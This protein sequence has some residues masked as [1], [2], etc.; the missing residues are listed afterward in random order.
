[1]SRTKKEKKADHLSVGRLLAFKSSDVSQAGIQA[2]I[3][4]YLTIYCTDTFG[5]APGTLGVLL[6]ASKI[7]DAITDLFAGWLVDNTHTKLGK[8]RPYD[9][10]IVGV[11]LCS[12]LLFAGDPNW[13]DAVKC[14]WVFLMY[15][16]VFS[17]FTTLRGAAVTPYTIRAFH[18]NQT[19]IT[20]V[21]SYGGIITML[22]AIIINIVFPQVM[23]RYAVDASGWTKTIAIFAIPLTILG[24]VRFFTCKE[25]PSVDAGEQYKK[26]SPKEILEMFKRNKYVWL[27]AIIMLCY[28]ITT[29]LGVATYYFKYVIGNLGLMSISSMTSIITLPVMFLFPVIMRKMGSMSNMVFRFSLIGIAGYLIELFAG[30]NFPMLLVGTLI[31]GIATLPLA[32]YGVL[33]IMRCCTYN[34]MLGMPRMDASAGILSNFMSKVG[35]AA[36]SAITGIL[37]GAAGYISGTDVAAQPDSAILM[38]RFLMAGVPIICLIIVSICVKKFEKLEIEIPKWEEEQKQK[39]AQKAGN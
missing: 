9:L 11:T 32:Y 17:V 34:Q 39:A 3:L 36:G 21:A 10:C 38:I 22:G 37:L 19:L 31:S 28:N 26:V 13:A 7:V 25:D 12:I 23:T 18:N 5:I 4:G 14:A 2:I 33:F 35:S 1:M 8:A 16:L 20:K 15:T 24:L 29:A 30:S 6:M 27:Y